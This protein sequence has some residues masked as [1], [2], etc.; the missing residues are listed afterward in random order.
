M[1]PIN[2][3]KT[4]STANTRGEAGIKTEGNVHETGANCGGLYQSCR[5]N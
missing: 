1:K 2:N 3:T 4:P 5:E